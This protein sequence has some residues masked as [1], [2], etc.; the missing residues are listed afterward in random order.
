MTTLDP[1]DDRPVMRSWLHRSQLEHDLERETARMIEM[2]ERIGR[3]DLAAD[4]LTS[5]AH[6]LARVE[7]LR[8]LLRTAVEHEDIPAGPCLA[9]VRSRR[10]AL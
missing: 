8:G 10:R 7:R 1:R 5:Y 9:R 6:L 4:D 2:A 3:R